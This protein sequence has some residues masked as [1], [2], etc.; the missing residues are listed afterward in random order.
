[1]VTRRKKYDV[2]LPEGWEVSTATQVHGRHLTPGMEVS[3]VGLR[4]RFRFVKRV[5]TEKGSWLVLWGG[6]TGKEKYHHVD[7]EKVRTVHRLT[8]MREAK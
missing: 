1:M 2:P 6:K 7:P 3:V 8:K 4:G 5:D